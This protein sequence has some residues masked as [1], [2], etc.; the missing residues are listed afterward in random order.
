MIMN[1]LIIVNWYPPDLRVPA[2]RWY[3]LVSYL[4][5]AGYCCTVVSAG[6]GK[7]SIHLGTSGEKVIR[8]SISNKDIKRGESELTVQSRRSAKRRL[9]E[10][11][12]RTIPSSFTRKHINYWKAT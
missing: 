9:K 8:V 5:Q 6:D 4:Q 3:N 1:F 7:P 11:L 2:K 12:L 10:C